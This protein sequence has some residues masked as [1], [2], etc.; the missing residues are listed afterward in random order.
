M[1][2]F[3]F[4]SKIG[5]KPQKPLTEVLSKTSQTL[6]G[7]FSKMIIGKSTIDKEILDRLEELLIGSDVGVPTT[8]K[9]ITA[10]E[11]RVARDRYLT[12]DELKQILQ[13]EVSRLLV[14]TSSNLMDATS[15]PYVV[16]V[17]GINGVGKTTTIGKLAAQ[18]IAAEKKVIL[19]AADTFRAAAVEQLTIWGSRVKAKVVAPTTQADPSAVAYDAVQQGI[20]DGVDVVLI[21]TAGRLH[22]KTH[23]IHEL[24]KIKRTIQKCLPNAPH[25]VLLVLDGTTGQNAYTQAEVFTDAVQVTGIVVTKLDGTAK[26]GMLLGIADQF[27][28]PIRYIGTGEKIEDL[29]PFD[30]DTFVTALFQ[31]W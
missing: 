14:T 7:K 29:N 26:G 2:V 5:R 17:V 19:G 23:L 16:L 6:W 3:D 24:S 20:Q 4:L 13:D 1:G 15:S 25:E 28:I 21:D 10:I 11:Q 9:I 31:S 27:G 12:I 8:L 22:T 18:F 30:A